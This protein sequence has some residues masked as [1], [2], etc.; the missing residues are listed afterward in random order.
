[1][2]QELSITWNNIARLR[3]QTPFLQEHVL[4]TSKVRV[5]YQQQFRIGQRSLLDLLNTEN[6][7]FDAQRALVNAQYDLKKAEY[8][9]L[10]LS[11]QILPVLGLAQP[12]STSR[13]EEQQVL[14]LPDDMLRSCNAAV[15]DTSNL[16]PVSAMV[17]EVMVP[18][19]T[20]QAEAPAQAQTPASL[21]L[22][23]RLAIQ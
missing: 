10:A 17:S 4:S 23:R 7:L 22:T 19:K 14:T 20:A 11:S 21:Q 3:Q 9:W 6:E 12:H 1:M 15:P 5:A 8:Q 16:A 2:L 13:P 18:V